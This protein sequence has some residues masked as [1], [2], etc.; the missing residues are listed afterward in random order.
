MPNICQIYAKCMPKVKFGQTNALG[1]KFEF[2]C[3]W[4]SDLSNHWA[5]YPAKNIKSSR[6]NVACPNLLIL[7][8]KL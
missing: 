7:L 5:T 2:V 8:E 4:V 3:M 1:A 6:H